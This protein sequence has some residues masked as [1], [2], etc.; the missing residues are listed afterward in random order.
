VLRRYL[1]HTRVT[2]GGGVSEAAVN[3]VPIP[4]LDDR[5]AAIV[6]A[7]QLAFK[8]YYRCESA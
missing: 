2:V 3:G 1:L 8:P 4:S 6:A 5:A 7:R